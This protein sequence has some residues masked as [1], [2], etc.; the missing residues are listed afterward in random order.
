MAH[1]PTIGLEIHAILKT[2]T[3]MFCDSLNDLEEREPNKNVCPVCLGHPGTLPTINKKAV[4]HVIRVGLALGGRIAPVS[5]FDRKNYFYPDLPKGY[6]ISQ[7]DQPIVTGGELLGVRVR[8][9]HL[10][11]DAG[12]LLHE[13][14]G[15][16]KKG[17]ASYVD[18]NRA[19][20]P[21]LELVTEPDIRSAE[22]TVESAREL[23]RI[24]RYL[25]VSDA[26]M[27]KGQMRVEANV[28]LDMGP[29]VELKNINSFKAVGAAIDYEVKRQKEVLEGGGAVEHETRGWDEAKQIT[30][31]QRGKEEAHDYRYFP[32]PDLPAFETEGFEPERLRAELPELPAA[33]RERFAR[34]FRLSGAQ[35][36]MLVD[37]KPVADFFEEA[38]SELATMDEKDS[39]A[40]AKQATSLL[41]NY[42]T[43]DLLGL[44]SASG[45]DFQK[46]KIKPEGL[47]HLADLI[48]DGKIMSR[49]AKEI[50]RKMFETGEDPEAIMRDEGLET[51]SD[52]GEVENAVREV[53][54]ANPKAAE[55]F[56]KGKE[57]SL[58]FLLGQ[59]MAKLRGRGDPEQIREILH[60]TLSE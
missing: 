3:K 15:E 1:Q 56:K 19:G 18:F 13:I 43:S 39:A 37:M 31:S 32:E 52:Q 53:I 33:K 59:A 60:R 50:L 21:L 48:N 20:V 55:D 30:V 24:L 28:S 34:E 16:T 22:Q 14:P 23:Q 51:V 10:E 4:E 42:L 27:E 45:G 2:R 17:Q 12:R 25:E 8:R 41:F 38:V 9:V 57:A 40:P 29:K 11:E 47:A 54:A 36:A 35:A 7:Y 58:K 46:I 5:K 49:Q 44:V 26:D 6:Q